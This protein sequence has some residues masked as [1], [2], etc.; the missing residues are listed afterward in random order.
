MRIR[1]IINEDIQ[2]SEPVELHISHDE[3]DDQWIVWFPHP[4]GGKEILGQFD[5]HD[6]AK[7][8]W[9]EQVKSQDIT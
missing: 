3:D 2:D 4:L 8:F 9:W 7:E 6:E 1:E 5:N